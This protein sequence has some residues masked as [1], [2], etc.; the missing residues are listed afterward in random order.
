[1]VMSKIRI[2]IVALTL[3]VVSLGLVGCPQNTVYIQ[4][5]NLEKAIRLAI[6]KPY[7]L[8]LTQSDLLLLQRLDARG[9][10]IR[11]LD[12]LENC[13]N[14]FWLDLEDNNI[15]DISELTF[16]INLEY[17]NLDSNQVTD[18]TPL[19][20]LL[21]LDQVSLVGNQILDISPLVANAKN[22]G[23]G[24]GNTVMLDGAKIEDSDAN[25]AILRDEMEVNVL[26]VSE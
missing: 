23:L 5:Q 26:L 14:L 25:V 11:S 8:G 10:E 17:V 16:L 2:E 6:D 18:I 3:V 20:G 9:M 1:M 21:Y 4:D 13:L 12:G 7:G 19:A 24:A 15:S 22:G